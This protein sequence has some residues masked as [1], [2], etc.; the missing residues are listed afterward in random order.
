MY[1]EP[2]QRI[3]CIPVCSGGGDGAIDV[4]CGFYIEIR[5]TLSGFDLL[6]GDDAAH[7]ETRLFQL[8]CFLHAGGRIAQV[9]QRIYDRQSTLQEYVQ[10]EKKRKGK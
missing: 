3:V 4:H 6:H 1:S 7:A 5:S 10:K 8:F 2:H 9:A